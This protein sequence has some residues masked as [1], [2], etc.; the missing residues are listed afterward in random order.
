M[1]LL[2][3]ANQGMEFA[4]YLNVLQRQL[5]EGNPEDKLLDYVF[6]NEK[7][8]RRIIKKYEPADYI[9]KLVMEMNQPVTWLAITEGWC[10]DA[11]HALPVFHK[12]SNL[13]FKPR[14]K[15]VFR[16]EN[17]ELMDRFLT[18]GSRAIPKVIAINN[19]NGE[20]ITEWGP[21]PNKAQN[22]VEEYK[23]GKSIYRNYNEL[24]KALQLWYHR[25]RYLN[26]ENEIIEFI[27]PQIIA[28]QYRQVI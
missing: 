4:E 8:M 25:D 23:N 22:I 3:I 26:F 15:I 28:Q 21:R 1:D 14:L 2:Q 5:D 13:S 24:S 17:P 7:R 19:Q 16:D 18:N 11:A 10:G 6:L 27:E 20:V 12:L 9:A